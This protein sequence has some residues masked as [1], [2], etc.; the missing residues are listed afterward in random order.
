MLPI[1]GSV[2]KKGDD[3]CWLDWIRDIPEM[4]STSDPDIETERTSRESS[5]MNAIS[6]LFCEKSLY[7]SHSFLMISPYIIPQLFVLLSDNT[8]ASRLP[9][10]PNPAKFL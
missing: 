3:G 9:R 1:S 2:L 8:I 5:A 10:T 6:S 7:S 4:D